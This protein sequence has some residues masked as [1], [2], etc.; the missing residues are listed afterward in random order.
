MTSSFFDMSSLVQG[1]NIKKSEIPFVG[2]RPFEADE[3]HLFFGRDKQIADLLQK[4]YTH[5]FLAI[6]GSSGCGKSSLIRAGVIPHLKAGFLTEKRDHWI[7]A[8]FRPSGDPLFHFCNT[9]NEA[10][11]S[12]VNGLLLQKPNLSPRDLTEIGI[13][14]FI[15]RMHELMDNQRI[16]LLI[17]ADQFE[18]LFTYKTGDEKQK[19]DNNFFVNLLLAL[20]G[21][22]ELPVYTIITMRS[23]YIGH[24][25]RFFG[26]PE[27]LNESQYLVPRLKWYQVREV[28]ELP[29]KLFGQEIN[30]GLLDLLTNDSDKELDQLP[31]L[32]H[33]LMRTY[34]NWIKAGRLGP[35]DFDHYEK[36]GGLDNALCC[37]VNA[38]FDKLDPAQQHI[39]EYLFRAITDYNADYEPIRRPQSFD[40]TVKI[41]EAVEGSSRQDVLNVI[42]IFRDKSCAFLTP[43]E[44]VKNVTGDT[45]ID[46]SHESLMRQWD[47]LNEWIR[48]EQR[49]ADKLVWLSE[50]VTNQREYLRGWDI[51]DALHWKENQKPNLEWA[52]RYVDNLPGVLDYIDK[53]KKSNRK[54]KWMFYGIVSLTSLA[55]ITTLV[56]FNNL[57]KQKALNELS[58]TKSNLE[59]ANG[60]AREDSI[61]KEKALL[62]SIADE[63]EAEKLRANFAEHHA[64]DER[65]KIKR[66]AKL[67]QDQQDAQLA[68]Q[69]EI[70]EKEDSIRNEA[71]GKVLDLTKERFYQSTEINN[72]IKKAYVLD[73][74]KIRYDEQKSDKIIN[75]TKFQNSLRAL[76]KAAEGLEA[77]KGDQNRGLWIVGQAA[78][79][80]SKEKNHNVLDSIFGDLM[81]KYLFYSKKSEFPV[82]QPN[83]NFLPQ[84]LISAISKEKDLFA[85]QEG[86]SIRVISFSPD[87][88]TI[89]STF[90][91]PISNNKVTRGNS[92][93]NSQLKRLSFKDDNTLLGLVNDSVF[94]NWNLNGEEIKRSVVKSSTSSQIKKISPD[95]SMIILGNRNNNEVQ[96]RNILNNFKEDTLI[97]PV[98]FGTISDIDIEISPDSKTYLMSWNQGLSIDNFNHTVKA[99]SQEFTAG[100]FVNNNTVIAYSTDEGFK[101]RSDSVKTTIQLLNTALETKSKK[102]DISRQIGSMEILRIQVS[103]DWTKLMIQ[104]LDEDMRKDFFIVEKT[105]GD[106]IFHLGETGSDYAGKLIVKKVSNSTAIDFLKNGLVAAYQASYDQLSLSLWKNYNKLSVADI[107]SESMPPLSNS[108]KIKN[109]IQLEEKAISLFAVSKDTLRYCND[110]KHILRL[111]DS[112]L[113][114]GSAEESKDVKNRL[115]RDYGNLS[116]YSMFDPAINYDSVIFYASKGLALDSIKNN[117]IYT[118]L[119]LGYL[120]SGKYKKAYNVYGR[121]KDSLYNTSYDQRPFKDGFLGD[122]TDLEKAGIIPD[123][124]ELYERIRKIKK[125][126]KNEITTLD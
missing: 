113:V 81:D 74:I 99:S 66:A 15:K 86:D 96:I 121:L 46:I 60:R 68:V 114:F 102:I 40:T 32:Q 35:I 61:E 82:S 42:N 24:C 39:A 48:K 118:N 55:I 112:I 77:V 71:M 89:K 9:I 33:C 59:I 13:S 100:Y 87:R 111:G 19:N 94:Y 65:E 57:K 53:S 11:E 98:S 70:I 21:E 58:K 101:S 69:R 122:F 79:E 45:I 8:T 10:F 37:H 119:A 28:I 90:Y 126:L 120:F 41:C 103:P 107:G 116:F 5:Q 105:K 34:K 92:R 123:K 104:V 83:N 3:S 30:P 51:E 73:L 49:S 97:V 63:A 36:S 93:N 56:G 115:S 117:W 38:V 85:Y 124:G 4:L 22:K 80:Y 50:S 125:F 18:E 6:V 27:L 26:L 64:N 14:G 1:M 44:S 25:N 88:I 54:R 52:N 110:L 2:L 84:N 78:Q 106:S 7:V 76:N 72:E 75:E 17:L 12:N 91:I 108:D 95:G 109:W 23:D 62:K 43:P 16:N 67:R 20:A 47:R 29:I 31:V